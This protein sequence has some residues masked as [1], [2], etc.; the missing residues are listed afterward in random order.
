MQCV[1]TCSHDLTIVSSTVD[2][3]QKQLHKVELYSEWSGIFLQPPK[4]EA[5]G[6]IRSPTST[7][8][9]AALTNLHVYG[10]HFS[11]TASPTQPKIIPG[12]KSSRFLGTY[13]TMTLNWTAQFD[14][15]IDK[16]TTRGAQIADC[17]LTMAQKLLMENWCLLGAIEHTYCVAPYSPKQL[18]QLDKLR[19]HTISKIK[20][21]FNSPRD[22]IFLA[23]ED[24]GLGE[25]SFLERFTKS[26]GQHIVTILNDKSRL[27]TAARASLYHSPKPLRAVRARGGAP[28]AGA[29]ITFANTCTHAR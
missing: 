23:P 24:Y 25:E 6:I 15:L 9:E 19:A 5:S 18:K 11:L 17:R 20:H 2:P 29:S 10:Q 14:F 12:D 8:A 28:C 16:L 26:I 13:L 3:L 21:L 7:T 27:G 22:Y 4:C 1:A